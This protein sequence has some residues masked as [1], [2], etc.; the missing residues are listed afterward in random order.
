MGDYLSCAC[1]AEAMVVVQQQ[2]VDNQKDN[3]V[4]AQLGQDIANQLNQDQQIQNELD[5]QFNQ[6][7]INPINKQVNPSQ[8]LCMCTVTWHC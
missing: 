2:K 4:H 8:D 1:I 3:S 6:G 5:Q 7:V